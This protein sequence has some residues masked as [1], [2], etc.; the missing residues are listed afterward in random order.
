MPLAGK[1]AAWA[2]QIK[3]VLHERGLADGRVAIDVLDYNGFTALQPGIK[4]TDADRTM[5]AARIIK[6]PAEIELMRRACAIAELPLHDLEQAIRPGMTENEL[7]AT[8]WHRML[9]LGGE[10]CFSRLVV[11]GH[12]TNPLVS[13]GRQQ[14]VAPGDLV[15]SI[16]T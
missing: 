5:S 10:H 12:K 9:A 3:D 2:R 11:S 4:L 16:P 13:R 7:L 8:F 6:M 1:A 15:A 14:A